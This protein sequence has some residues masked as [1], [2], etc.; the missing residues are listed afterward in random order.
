MVLVQAPQTVRQRTTPRDRGGRAEAASGTLPRSERRAT[1]RATDQSGGSRRR[2][3]AKRDQGGSRALLRPAQATGSPA[4]AGE[5]PSGSRPGEA[6]S[7]AAEGWPTRMDRDQSADGARPTPG[8]GEAVAGAERTEA[9]CEERPA[10]GRTVRRA[11]RPSPRPEEE[12]RRWGRLRTGDEMGA[13]GRR[14]QTR[15][16]SRRRSP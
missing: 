2:E 15:P 11:R 1:V 4:S 16:D 3:Q 10:R 12:P 5:R 13:E 7:G 9:G 14:R 6:A 8:G